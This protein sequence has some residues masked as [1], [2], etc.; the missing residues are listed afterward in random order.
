MGCWTYPDAEDGCVDVG[1]AGFEGAV[2]VCDGAVA[3]VV[4]VGFD[5]T[6]YDTSERP[7]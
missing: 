6:A 2:G 1:C 7:D 3:V 5:V 4:E